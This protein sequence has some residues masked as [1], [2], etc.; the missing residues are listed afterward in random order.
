MNKLLSLLLA[1]IIAGSCF[2]INVYAASPTPRL[3][4]DFVPGIE[5]GRTVSGHVW[6]EEGSGDF[7][8]YAVTMALAVTKGGRIWAPKP[9]S[10]TPSVPLNSDGSFECLFVSGG[11]DFSAEE[12]YVCLIPKAFDPGS[13][14]ERTEDNALDTVMIYR[15]TDGTVQIVQKSEPPRDSEADSTQTGGAQMDSTQTDG[16]QMDGAQKN[17]KDTPKLSLCFSPYTNGLNPNTNSLVP[18]EHMKWLFNL[19]DPY[20][21]TVR[22]FGTSGELEKA[23]RLAK[24]A[25]GFRVIGGCWID[26]RYTEKQIYAE[27]DGLIKLADAGLIDI[28]VV[29]S[30]TRYRNDFSAD[31]LITYINY[32]KLGIKDKSIPV[33]TSDTVAAFLENQKLVDA[34][35]VILMTCYPFFNN[36]PIEEAPQRL[37]DT[38]DG[39]KSKAG[40]KQVIIS[41]TGW[42]DAG[43]PEGLSAP[44]MENCRKYF[45]AVYSWSRQENVEV[46][47]FEEVDELWKDTEGSKGDVGQHWGYFYANG[48][49]KEAYRTVYNSISSKPVTDA[50]SAKW[51]ENEI[52]ELVS[53]GVISPDGPSLYNP[54]LPIKRGELMHYL[55]N[56]L[57]PSENGNTAPTFSDISPNMYYY[58]SVGLGQKE[59]L[60]SGI[61]NDL[62]GAERNLSREDLFV[63]ICRAMKYAGMDVTPDLNVLSGYRDKAL[64]SGYAEEA[65][66]ALVRGGIVSGDADG[67]LNPQAAA[68]RAE[69]AILLYRIY[70]HKADI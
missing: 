18:M 66:S 55:V 50:E 44:G 16:A 52:L 4:V 37:F 60:I 38:Y 28:A 25:Y 2:S 27:L 62:S 30:E 57:F 35:D 32:V 12:L 19:I 23:Y 42:P 6:F 5:A 14:F 59:G 3:A 7:S 54:K 49:L 69:A 33:T 48:I 41:E 26:A 36:T 47:F 9:T 65:V 24:E 39:V 67:N 46:V 70:H 11:Y 43:S 63:L 40:G 34:C 51:A 15:N 17:P 29:G 53:K 21:D 64:V 20:A 56:T 22:I 68:T 13:D 31:R 10:D 45:E 1:L 58:Y 61:G 8:Q